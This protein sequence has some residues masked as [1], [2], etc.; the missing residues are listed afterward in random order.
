MPPSR[1]CEDCLRGDDH[2]YTNAAVL[3]AHLDDG[4][5]EFCAARADLLIPIPDAIG[6]EQAAAI[7]LQ[8]P[9]AWNLLRHA[10]QVRAGESVLVMAAAGEIG[11]AGVNI[12][13]GLGPRHRRSRFI[14]AS[15]PVPE[16]L[17]LS[18]VVIYADP[19]W[20]DRV[21]ELTGGRGVEIIFDNISSSELFDDALRSL[22]R[23][24]WL[25]TCGWHG[26]AGGPGLPRPPRR[27]GSLLRGTRDGPLAS[28]PPLHASS[29]SPGFL[30]MTGIS[31]PILDR[32]AGPSP[33]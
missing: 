27:F 11:I 33:S 15:T 20:S 22:R 24:G 32:T 10:G 4:Y 28:D 3:G 16:F 31:T 5:T 17:D 13:C 29:V 23:G 6:F 12:A 26:D 8:Y 30:G 18:D 14:A 25:V 21:R 2:L 7:G 19:G 1:H 9:A